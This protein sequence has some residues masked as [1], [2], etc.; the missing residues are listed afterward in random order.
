M[1]EL[2]L[3]LACVAFIFLA[4]L[5]IWRKTAKLRFL[6]SDLERGEWN[7]HYRV[8]VQNTSFSSDVR[9]CCVRIYDSE[10]PI[11]HVPLMMHSPQNGLLNGTIELPLTIPPRSHRKWDILIDLGDSFIVPAANSRQR[12]RIQR[13][14]YMI[15]L[16]AEAE[17][18]RAA[19]RT[20]R[21]LVGADGKVGFSVEAAR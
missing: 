4:I 17:N 5:L 16:I 7:G 13:R 21:V 18:A 10:P 20:Y 19:F 9:N 3:F 14:S 2:K 8:A 1:G 6:D 15:T 11:P 12:E